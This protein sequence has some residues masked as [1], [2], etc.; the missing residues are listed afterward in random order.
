VS[1]E[2]LDVIRKWLEA[3]NSTDLDGFAGLFDG[4]AEVMTDPLWMEW[5]V[6]RLFLK[7]HGFEGGGTLGVA[8][9]AS[10]LSIAKGPNVEIVAPDLRAA[11]LD[12]A[13]IADGS[14]D[15]TVIGTQHLSGD[16]EVIERL[17][18]ST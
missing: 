2:N 11:A 7:S 14:D 18:V 1:Q 15:V 8:G 10:H 5:G 4:D 12:P 13:T 9:K 6:S 16:M 17:E 3:W